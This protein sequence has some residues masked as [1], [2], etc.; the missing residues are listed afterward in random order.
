MVEALAAT[1]PR[2]RQRAKARAKSWIR[3]ELGLVL[4]EATGRRRGAIGALRWDDLDF[5]RGRITWR[6]AADK[7]RRTSV[8]AYPAALFD[9][10]REFQRRLG[11]VG[12][13]SVPRI[14]DSERSHHPIKAVAVVGGWT[15]YDTM[16][17]CYH[18]PEDE[19]V[20]A[21]TSEPRKRRDRPAC[22]LVND[23]A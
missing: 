17:R 15:D 6:A 10:L 16:T 12:G 14:H 5:K 9:S 2:A 23:A 21:V 8:V 22:D 20:L 4:L 1:S 3:G 7:K 11:D 19:D 13:V 18:I